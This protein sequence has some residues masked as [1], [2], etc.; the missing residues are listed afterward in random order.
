MER[1]DEVHSPHRSA[2]WQELPVCRRSGFDDDDDD[3]DDGDIIIIII[4]LEILLMQRCLLILNTRKRKIN[5]TL[6]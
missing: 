5:T 6:F 3:D 4:N 2:L 1:S